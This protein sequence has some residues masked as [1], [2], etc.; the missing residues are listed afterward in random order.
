MT[1]ERQ[2][3]P[4]ED[5]AAQSNPTVLDFILKT[6][7]PT[8]GNS[9]R[10]TNARCS[11]DAQDLTAQRD[12]LVALG[13]KPNRIYVDHGLTGTNRARPGL[14]EALAAC[15]SGDTLVVTK[16][17]RLA[18]SLTD[19]RNIVEEL[20][21]AGVKLNIGGSLHDPTDPVGRLLFN[22]LGM[23]AEFESDLI[24][25]RT[26][27]GMKVAKAKGRLRGKQ[28]KLKPAQEAH[29]VELWRAGKHT[30]AE[31]AELFSVARS[32]VYRAVQRAGR[33]HTGAS[34]AFV[35]AHVFVDETKQRGYLLVASVVV[36]SD[37]DSV[38]RMLRG[39][40][41]PGQRRLHMKD[42][43]DQRR[44]SIA[45]AIAVSGVTATIYDA[46]RRYR[47]ER[48]RRAACLHTLV[49][50]AAR[51]GD[52]MLVL[53]QDDT[54]LNWDNQ[55]LIEFTREAGC[56]DTLR[57]EHRRAASELLLAAPDAVAWCWAK[58]GDWRRRIEPI[59]TDVRTV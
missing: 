57:Y 3:E 48:E 13:V 30:S 21:E 14:R 9:R 51:R 52:A 16:L 33:A 12:A 36:P 49:R 8:H 34:S 38:R 29:L 55:R 47:N 20:T 15:R 10:P 27:E 19:A 11:T 1:A 44:R 59:V 58:G 17:D 41:L 39:L 7:N 28:P 50:D 2:A 32:T 56:R 42:E 53:E 24:R 31:L 35:S 23:I 22:V 26:R 37:L 45:T 54:L 5:N 4:A 25:M 6:G 43:N 18:R 46:G 40:V